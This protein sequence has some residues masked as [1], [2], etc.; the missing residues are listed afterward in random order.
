VYMTIIYMV[1]VSFLYGFFLNK[2]VVK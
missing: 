2:H 1:V